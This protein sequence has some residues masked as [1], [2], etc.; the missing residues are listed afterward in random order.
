MSLKSFRILYE[1]TYIIVCVK[2]SGIATQSKSIKS[3]DMVSI[4]KNH[5]AK[6][7]SSKNI[8]K[9]PYLGIIHRKTICKKTQRTIS[10]ASAK[11]GKTKRS[12]QD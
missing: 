9:E 3:P 11:K 2:P 12:S 7:A 6:N 10:P 8:S 1:D 5:I 4:L